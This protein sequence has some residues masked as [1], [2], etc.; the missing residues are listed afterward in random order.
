M[1][2][3]EAWQPCQASF[4]FCPHRAALCLPEQLANGFITGCRENPPPFPILFP[5]IKLLHFVGDSV[6]FL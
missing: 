1:I 5:P 3:K 4:F 6:K 2:A